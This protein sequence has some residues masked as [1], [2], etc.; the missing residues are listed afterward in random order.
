MEKRGGTQVTSAAVLYG[1]TVRGGSFCLSVWG[2]G[3]ERRSECVGVWG[4]SLGVLRWF[5]VMEWNLYFRVGVGFFANGI[6][7]VGDDGW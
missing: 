2:A 7:V 5:G 4:F 6:F 1:G 3:H